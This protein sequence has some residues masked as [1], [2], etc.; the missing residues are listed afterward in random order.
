MIQ[1]PRSIVFILL[2]LQPAELVVAH[3][4]H[5]VYDGHSWHH[6]VGS[7]EHAWPLLVMIAILIAMFARQYKA[8]RIK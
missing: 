2:M 8:S 3:N 7:S 1:I 5:G 6:F 4:G